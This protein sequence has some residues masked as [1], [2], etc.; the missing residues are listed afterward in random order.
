[1]NF[2]ISKTFTESLNCRAGNER[3]L[4]VKLNGLDVLN[5]QTGAVESCNVEGIACRFFDADYNEENFFVRHSCFLG[6]ND[7]YSSLKT[8]LKAKIDPEAWATLNSGKSRASEK[9]KQRR[10]AVKVINH[11]GDELMK[12]FQIN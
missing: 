11:Q 10:I 1:M 9:P 6:A 5:P 7:P 2:P 8:T 4:C 3:Y 12:V